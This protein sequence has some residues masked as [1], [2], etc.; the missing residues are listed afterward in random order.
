MIAEATG[1]VVKSMAMMRKRPEKNSSA[2]DGD[3]E[4]GEI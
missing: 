2:Q 4:T 3:H 1:S